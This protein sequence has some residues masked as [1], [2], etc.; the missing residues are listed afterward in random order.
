MSETM[1]LVSN[2]QLS[3]IGNSIRTKLG[4]STTYTVDEMPQKISSISGSSLNIPTFTENVSTGVVTC[5]KTYAECLE[6]LDNEEDER[7][8]Y[9]AVS[10]TTP[11][12]SSVLTG[13]FYYDESLDQNIC[14]YF[15]VNSDS[16]AVKVYFDYYPDGDIVRNT[17]PEDYTLNTQAY[18]GYDTVNV[19]SY[20]A[21]DVSLTVSKTSYY[22]VSWMGF[23]N[24]TSGTSG[25]Q[26]YING[27][28]VGSEY[29]TFVNSYGQYVCFNMNL[30]QGDVLTV[31]AKAGSTA[32]YMGVGNLIIEEVG[33][34]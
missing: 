6:L 22:S 24:T 20:T 9:Y 28:A 32:Y 27:S 13:S 33:L 18:R 1:Y 31:Y 15:L 12:Y 29:T 14:R 19:A 11:V 10:D 25:S 21:T 5:D 34:M 23:R 16:G 26:L 2:N 30:N 3:S 7:T 8:L 17:I 4:E